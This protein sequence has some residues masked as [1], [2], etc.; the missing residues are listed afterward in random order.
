MGLLHRRRPADPWPLGLPVRRGH[1]RGHRRR[2][3]GQG[4]G[5]SPAH[6]RGAAPH[7][8]HAQGRRR[9]G[10]RVGG[11]RR[12]QP[13]RRLRPHDRL[14]RAREVQADGC[15]RRQLR[16]RLRL[17][18]PRQDGGPEAGPRDLL[19]RTHLL[20]RRHA[21]HG[22][23]QRRRGPRRP[24]GGGPAGGWGGH[25]QEPP[26]PADA[27]VRVQ[28]RRRRAHGPAGVRR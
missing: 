21:H 13:A 26:G 11:R 6:P 18:V 22:C 24:R 14:T 7:P 16:R 12:A 25:G 20:G 10:E 1:H 8:H 27:E 5:R 28:P 2:A 9:R 17:R 23:G 19:P 3:P 15:R 4:R